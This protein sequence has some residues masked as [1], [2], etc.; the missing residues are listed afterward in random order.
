MRRIIFSS[1]ACPA[2]LYSST[3]SHKRYD[4]RS[5]LTEHMCVWFSTTFFQIFL[6]ALAKLRKATVR[7]FMS[8]RLPVLPSDRMQQLRPH[9]K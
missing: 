5:N 3:L 4:F 7:F 6:G 8:V 1:V 2:V 9:G